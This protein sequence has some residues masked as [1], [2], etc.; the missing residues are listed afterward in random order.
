MAARC[1]A[2]RTPRSTW[3]RRFPATST[4]STCVSP[5]R[6]VRP[7]WFLARGWRTC[8]RTSSWPSSRDRRWRRC[9]RSTCCWLPPNFVPML[10]ELEIVV[11][12]AIRMVHPEID[13][14]ARGAASPV[15]DV[16]RTNVDA[17]ARRATD[18]AGAALP[19]HHPEPS[20]PR[21]RALVARG[22]FS[23]IR[24]GFLLAGDL[25]VAAR[26]GQA[27]YPAIE[28]GRWRV[29]SVPGAYRWLFR[30]ARAARFAHRQSRLSRL[31]GRSL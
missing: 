3:F 21:R 7:R 27:A 18:R 1:W 31:T 15:H 20:E 10:A 30:A 16:P 5:P 4:S 17:S 2:S 9:A 25:E 19:G 26:L 29:I 13:I 6:P 24:A 11:R 12:A 14:P 28:S 8:A 22:L 23:T